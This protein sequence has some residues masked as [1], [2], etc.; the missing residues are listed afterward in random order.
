MRKGQNLLGKGT[1]PNHKA[2]GENGN[3]TPIS[4]ILA[5]VIINCQLALLWMNGNLFVLIT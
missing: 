3:H 5:E 1:S 4:M 2:I